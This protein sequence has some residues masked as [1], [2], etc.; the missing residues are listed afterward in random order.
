MLFVRILSFTNHAAEHIAL[1][2]PVYETFN[3]TSRIFVASL[4]VSAAIY[5]IA[6]HIRSFITPL[7]IG[8]AGLIATLFLKRFDLMPVWFPFEILSRIVTYNAGSE[9]GK[10]FTFTEYISLISALFTLYFSYNLFRFKRFQKAFFSSKVS[11]T[12]HIFVLS[13][14]IFLF[15]TEMKTIEM[16]PYNST[17][18]AGEIKSNTNFHK[19][20]LLDKLIGDT[21]LVIPVKNNKF[22]YKSDIKIDLDNYDIYF[23]DKQNTSICIS[24]NDSIYIRCILYGS[25]NRYSITGTRTAENKK[26]DELFI[27][28]GF[29]Y[30]IEKEL[31]AGR[32]ENLSKILLKE[33]KKS[34]S[35]IKN[36]RTADNIA[37]R[38]DYIKR[39]EKIILSIYLKEWSKIK[40]A[41]KML[42]PDK[43]I[44]DNPEIKIYKSLLSEYQTGLLSNEHYFNYQK[45][46]FIYENTENANEDTKIFDGIIKIKNNDFKDKLLYRHLLGVLYETPDKKERDS[47]VNL[48]AD[49][50]SNKIIQ[51]KIFSKKTLIDNASK[52]E[53]A[54]EFEAHDINGKSVKLDDFKGKYV[55]LDIWTTF[56]GACYRQMPYFE[57][58]AIKY[59]NKNIKF[60]SLCYIDKR[61]WNLDIAKKTNSKSVSWLFSDDKE[62]LIKGFNIVTI[63]RFILIDPEGNIVNSSFTYP[64]YPGFEELLMKTIEN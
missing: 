19:L 12:K 33:L 8:F 55:I 38:S 50:F 53:K 37:Y 5:A 36:F 39:K 25:D 58:F 51:K 26:Q 34:I 62:A 40:T 54:F 43:K 64:A 11:I 30:K 49:K 47:I 48:Y 2:F 10:F 18:I 4:F 3:L 31:T 7:L 20:T 28:R 60:I 56:C 35:K 57:K 27:E 22:H 52:G 13:V 24:T 32:S 59:K 16:R 61:K 1:N 23:D 21:L 14:F 6:I 29:A 17:V 41:Y 44:T 63:P 42:F 15:F 45:N 46:K 9:I